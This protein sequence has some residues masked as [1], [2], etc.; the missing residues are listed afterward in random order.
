MP[1]G[2]LCK[3]K[4]RV[5]GRICNQCKPLYWNMQTSNPLGCQGMPVTQ[6]VYHRALLKNDDP[7]DCDCNT[8]GTVSSLRVCGSEDGQCSCKARVTGRRCS[9]C[10]D[11]FFNLQEDDPFGCMG[12]I[13]HNFCL[14]SKSH[15]IYNLR[16]WM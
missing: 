8:A 13:T 2:E 10:G 6:F 15:H 16:L 9:E 4:E 1:K 11:G 5:Q 3:C 12:M 14:L 7:T